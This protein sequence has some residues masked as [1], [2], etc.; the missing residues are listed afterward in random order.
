MFDLDP[1]LQ[2]LLSYIVIVILSMYLIGIGNDFLETITEKTTQTHLGGVFV[3]GL[4]LGYNIDPDTMIIREL[5]SL[6]T[7]IDTPLLSLILTGLSILSIIEI[8]FGILYIWEKRGKIG[9]SGC[10]IVMC[11]G[12]LFPK[13]PRMAILSFLF[14]ILLFIYSEE[15]DF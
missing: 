15:S 1:S 12:Y 13:K 2:L 4:Y 7:V 11:S 10:G 3:S 14:G 5:V 6:I 9:V 8:F